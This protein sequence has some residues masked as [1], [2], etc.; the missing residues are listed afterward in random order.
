MFLTVPDLLPSL[1]RGGLRLV[2]PL[3]QA[4][5]MLE[6]Q[7]KQNFRTGVAQQQFLPE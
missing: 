3:C 2:V 6:P 1:H 4:E 5:L 7:I